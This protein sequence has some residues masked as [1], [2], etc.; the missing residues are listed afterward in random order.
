MDMLK[1]GHHF[2]TG[3]YPEEITNNYW[4]PV[5]M[6]ITPNASVRTNK[7]KPET[8]KQKHSLVTLTFQPTENL[9]MDQLFRS[10]LKGGLSNYSKGPVV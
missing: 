9:G 3:F 7:K 8:H 5:T 1:L 10:P 2:C 4:R 6:E